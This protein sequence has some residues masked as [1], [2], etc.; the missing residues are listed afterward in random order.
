MAIYNGDG[1]IFL[2][3]GNDPSYSDS[4]CV[5][6]FMDVMN[7]KA[8]SIG[9]T[10]SN[11]IRAAGDGENQTTPKDM[12]LLTLI[13]SSY[14]RLAEIWSKDSYVCRPRQ[15]GTTNV[16]FTS[17]VRNTILEASY[18]ILGG[19]TGHWGDSYA[20][21]CLCDV[22]GKQVAGYVHGLDSNQTSDRFGAMKELMDIASTI[23]SGGTTTDTVTK[24]DEAIAVLVPTYFAANYEQQTMEVLYAQ[25]ETNVIVPASTTKILTALTVLDWIE[26]V[27]ETFTFVQSDMIGGSG[28]VFKVGDVVSFKDALYA[29]ML[30]SS[31]QSA[32]AMARV[33]GRKIL[34]KG[35]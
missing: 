6:A 30:P 15:S 18:P 13:A 1:T 25:N 11:F 32:Q 35:T 17:T 14:K 12:V 3:I 20:L 5:D 10:N 26:D 28:A 19:K 27:N 33:V 22:G 23:L 16:S 31:N 2:N 9:M 8:A 4:T 24:A 29:L 34:T 7:A 21:A